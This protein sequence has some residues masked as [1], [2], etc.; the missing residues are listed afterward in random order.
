MA[1]RNKSY[2]FSSDQFRDA[3]LTKEYKMAICRD[4][5]DIY[6]FGHG[7]SMQ[8]DI[9]AY[10]DKFERLSTIYVSRN[11]G[12]MIVRDSKFERNIGTFGGAVLI[13]SPNWQV[14]KE[15]FVLFYSNKFLNNMAYL[16]GNAVYIRNTRRIDRMGDACAGVGFDSNYF[17]SNIGLK[18]SNGGAIGAVCKL[19]DNPLHQDYMASSAYTNFNR[20]TDNITPLKALAS[21]I[22]GLSDI[23]FYYFAFGIVKD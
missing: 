15:P 12:K 5:K 11:R 17:S 21:S 16:G 13:N 3:S 23:F 20:V 10:F 4:Q 14:R 2:V 18:T 19:L 8:D 22:L 7:V 6:M 1:K 9:D